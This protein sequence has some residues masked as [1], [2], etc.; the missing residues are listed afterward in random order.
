MS[1]DYDPEEL[2]DPIY[3][4]GVLCSEFLDMFGAEAGEKISSLCHQMGAALGKKLRN[5]MGTDMSFEGAVRAF[6]KASERGS[7]RT[8]LIALK[9]NRAV[10]EGTGCPYGLEGRGREICEAMM[11]VDRGV[12]ETASGQEIQVTVM[13][14]RADGDDHCEVVFEVA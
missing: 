9:N 6:V 5:V 8:R 7:A 13:R 3:A 4:F 12:L 14:T 11:S 2:G 1:I 10:L